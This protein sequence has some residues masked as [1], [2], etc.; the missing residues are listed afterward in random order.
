MLDIILSTYNGE[1]Y[2]K[3][4][5]ESILNQT[6][7]DWRLLIRDDGS[8]DRTLDIIEEYIK[9]FNGKIYFINDSDKHLG[10]SMSF[11]NLLK[12][13]TADYI[14]FCD[15][16]DV[17]LPNK[18]EITLNEMQNSEKFYPDKPVLIHSNLKVVNVGLKIIDE[19]FW[20]YQKLNPNLKRLNNLL[21]QNNVTGCTVMINRK[22]KDLLGTVLSNAIMHDWW[23]ALVASSFGVVEYIDKPLI[24]YRQHGANDTG[25]KRYKISYFINRSLKYDKAVK[26]INKII[27]QGKEF[28]SIY[29]NMLAKEQKDIVYNFI[30]LFEVGKFKRIYRIFKYKFFKYGFLRN[31]GFIIVMLIP[32][33]NKVKGDCR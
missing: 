15:Q 11:F 3:E 30:T 14:M 32:G 8:C 19:S 4:Q 12:Y 2:L 1:K 28:Y 29:G 10:A 24:L 23:L 31:L 20:K 6:Y 26:T 33:K 9:K 21:I 17:W 22:L 13:S 27:N 16:D 18:I 5:I 25:A 7:K